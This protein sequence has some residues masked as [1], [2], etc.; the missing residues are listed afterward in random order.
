MSFNQRQT[1]EQAKFSYSL[2]ANA[3][4]KETKKQIDTIKSL[5][6][7][8]KKDKLKQTKI[9]FLQNLMNDLIC[10]KLKEILELQGI[11]KK[12]DLNYRSKRRKAW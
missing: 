8:S 6:I 12:D 9:I 11:I 2:L 5:D 4:E 3:F 7:S 1:I 10:A